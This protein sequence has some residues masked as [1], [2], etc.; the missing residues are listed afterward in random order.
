MKKY[1]ILASL[2]FAAFNANA[3]NINNIGNPDYYIVL[4]KKDQKWSIVDISEATP[5]FNN[6][7]DREI[8]KYV[9][10]TNSYYPYFI[11]NQEYGI[12]ENKETREQVYRCVTNTTHKIYNP[13]D[14]SFTKTTPADVATSFFVNTIGSIATLSLP[15]L[16]GKIHT[17][18]QVDK[19]K[20]QAALIDVDVEKTFQLYLDRISKEKYK[21]SCE[22]TLKEA[23]NSRE[24]KNFV[25][26]CKD[27]YDDVTI[28]MA[29]K[30][31][32][33]LSKQEAVERAKRDLEYKNT[34]LEIERQRKERVA[35]ENKLME[36]KIRQI[37]IFRSSLKVEDQTNCGPVI[38]KKSK[39]VKVYFPVAN[40]GSEHWIP[41][42]LIKPS[43]YGC[44][45]VNGGYV[46]G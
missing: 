29:N 42:D 26:S 5:D 12:I 46:P 39:M 43:E 1:I 25:T 35:A 14:S 2:I 13:C 40:Y 16:S 19:D 24:Y 28:E 17:V 22:K 44:R 33:E 7:K 9:L 20:I 6:I 36:D 30:K 21:S 31:F 27:F 37:K 3:I 15:A 10:S 34:N 45:F 38:E 8:L 41:I 18:M 4:D 23:T 11:K 32:A